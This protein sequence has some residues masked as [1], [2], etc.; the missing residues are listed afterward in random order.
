MEANYQ[1]IIR[2]QILIS[3]IYL[4][5]ISENNLKY[6]EFQKR[7]NFWFYSFTEVISVNTGAK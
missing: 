3:T 6:L 5:Y 2:D 7:N 4:K 1:F